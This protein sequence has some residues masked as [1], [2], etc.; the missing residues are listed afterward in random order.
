M[1]FEHPVMLFLFAQV[2]TAGGTYAAIRADLREAI[3][4]AHAASMRADDAHRRIDGVMAGPRP[5]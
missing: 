3:I 5:R 2:V 1:K 4:T